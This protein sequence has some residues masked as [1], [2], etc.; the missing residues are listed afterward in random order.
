MAPQVVEFPNKNTVRDIP[1]M[2]RAFADR[3]E[4]GDYGDPEGV[5]VIVANDEGGFPKILAWGDKSTPTDCLV[6]LALGQH[7][8]CRGDVE[9]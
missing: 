8:L 1:E 3:L 7:W 9:R 5:F 6:Q 4:A 2:L